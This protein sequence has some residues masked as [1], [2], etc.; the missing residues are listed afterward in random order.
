MQ[1]WALFALSAAVIVVAGAALAVF[2]DVI[3]R[4]TGLGA[5]WF[6]AVVVALV[7]SLPELTTG[8]SAVRRDAPG[9]ALG[10]LFGSSMANM[11]ILAFVTLAFTKRRLLQHVALENVLT[12]MLAVALMALALVFISVDSLPSIA[13]VGLGVLAIGA[14]YV[15]GT[16]SIRERQASATED[17]MPPA[18]S[19]TFK[20]A[21]WGFAAAVL[22]IVI[23]APQLVAS[24]DTLAERTGL[25]DTFF[26]TL[27]LALVTTLPELAVSVSALRIGAQN[28]A[29]ANLL[30]SNAT[31]MAL[32]LPVGIAY[33]GDSLLGQAGEG[34]IVA[35]AT[36]ILLM[37]IGTI[38]IVLRAERQRLPVDLAAV[39]M[40]V[41][42]VLGLWAV[43]GA[44]R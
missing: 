28:L 19:I 9:L 13:G 12:A 43:Y 39:L 10:D 8:I 36:A 17:E 34:E 2:A 6:G 7:T 21:L 22:L 38:A 23:A 20:T 15:L 18:S 3:I 27:G 32:L 24:A 35:A 29:I 14:V 16:I 31:N 25:G 4:R 1:D 30:G 42:Y 26:G 41:V 11:A 44:S 40:L 33:K 37:S 5:L